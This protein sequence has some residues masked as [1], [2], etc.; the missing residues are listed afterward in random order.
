MNSN[1]SIDKRFGVELNA[2]ERSVFIWDR[3]MKLSVVVVVVV[4]GEASYFTIVTCQA[5]SYS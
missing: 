1:T 2:S 5:V 4:G 3:D